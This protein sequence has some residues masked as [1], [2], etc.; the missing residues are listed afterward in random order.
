VRL[1]AIAPSLSFFHLPVC[2]SSLLWVLV[3]GPSPLGL[4]R[5]SPSWRR[6]VGCFFRFP[7]ALALLG[8][9][10]PQLRPGVSVA[11]APG[12]GLPL[13]LLSGWVCRR[14]CGY[15][16]VWWFLLLGASRPSAVGGG[17]LFLLLSCHSFSFW[18]I[19]LL[20][21]IAHFSTSVSLEPH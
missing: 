18:A 2:E 13:R 1:V 16:R 11:L 5:S 15:L 3:V 14:L 7:L 12:R 21:A 10:R 8:Y 17:R 6:L 20:Q 9:F 19:A 4:L